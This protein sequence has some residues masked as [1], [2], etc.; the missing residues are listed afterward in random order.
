MHVSN[1]IDRCPLSV[2]ALSSLISHLSTF[3]FPRTE[4]P[5]SVDYCPLSGVAPPLPF[6]NAKLRYLKVALHIF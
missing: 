5:L 6:E 4:S 3:P 2:V 1:S